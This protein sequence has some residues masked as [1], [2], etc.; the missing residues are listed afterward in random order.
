MK[1]ILLADD[2]AFF[3]KFYATK[4]AEKGYTV[5]VAADGTEALSK[6]KQIAC[7][8]ILLDLVMPKKDGFAVLQEISDSAGKKHIPI[9]VFSTLGQEQDVQKAKELG[10]ED[11]IHKT[12]FNFDELLSKIQ[13]LIG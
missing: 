6:Y 10:A 2:D 5:E 9:I 12:F 11:F 3:Q 13:K 4:L 1:T 7:N 8:L